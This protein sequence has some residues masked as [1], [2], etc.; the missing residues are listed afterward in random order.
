MFRDKLPASLKSGP[1]KWFVQALLFSGCATLSG[2]LFGTS[3]IDRIK[4]RLME[5]NLKVRF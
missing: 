2:A 3:C 4:P 5:F 1:T